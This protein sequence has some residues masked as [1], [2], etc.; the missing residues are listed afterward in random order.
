MERCAIVATPGAAF[1]KAGE[2]FIRFTLTALSE[3]LLEAA[4][5]IAKMV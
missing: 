5:R 1:G 3:P 4:E 2:G